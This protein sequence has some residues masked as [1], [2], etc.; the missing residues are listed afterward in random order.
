MCYAIPGRIVDIKN[1]IA[2][3]DYF[4]EKREVLNEFSD[5]QLNDYVYAQGGIIIQKIDESKALSTLKLWKKRFHELKKIDEKLTNYQEENSIDSDF[6]KIIRKAEK[7]IDLSK[8]EMLRLLRAKDKHELET[9][10]RTANKIRKKTLENSSCVHGII[11]FSNYCINNCAYCGIQKDNSSLERYRMSVD[12]IVKTADYAANSLG[13]KALVLQS[14]EDSFY[15]SDKMVDIIKKI[16]EKCRVLLFVS[17][18]TKSLEDYRKMYDAG[19]R[20]ILLRFETS[21]QELY[22]KLHSTSASKSDFK[23]RINTLRYASKIGYLI[24]TGSLIGIPGQT[25]EDILNDILLTK[26]LNADMYSFGPLIA[27]P[28]T[29]LSNAGLIDINNMLKVIAVSRIIDNTSKI[30]VTTALE[31]LDNENGRKKGLFAG[32][33]SLMINVTPRKFKR[34]YNLYPGRP[35]KD[36]EI[37]QNISNTLKLLFSIGR[38]PTDLGI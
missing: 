21:N 29:N 3:V 16:K 14:G 26:S 5:V 33:N 37:T 38:A 30:L 17:V 20:G 19:A 36:K 23:K 15:T 22:R 8:S 18:G 4:G 12:E 11:E 6:K 34:L 13:F 27:H 28:K 7:R 31:T 9:L 1:N 25:E 10:F 32:A 2:I 35:D 24:A